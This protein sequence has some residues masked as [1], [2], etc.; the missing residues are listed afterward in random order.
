MDHRSRLSLAGRVALALAALLV[1][2]S[3]G[4][5]LQ[6]ATT[7][8]PPAGPAAQA[9]PQRPHG[10]LGGRVLVVKAAARPGNR[11]RRGDL[12]VGVLAA[13]L[14]GTVVAATRRSRIARS[15]HLQRRRLALGPRA[16]PLPS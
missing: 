11:H 5:S 15:R 13:A 6:P 3:S 10:I 1:L 8:A 16:P 2:S 9:T 12:L 14:A 4:S 7:G